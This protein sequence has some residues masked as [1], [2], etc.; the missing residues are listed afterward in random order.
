MFS[1][2]KLDYLLRILDDKEFNPVAYDNKVRTKIK[3]LYH[4]LDEIQSIGDDEYKVLYFCVEKGTIE[5]YISNEGFESDDEKILEYFHQ[6]NPEDLKWYKL[7]TV[8]YK[9][10]YSILLNSKKVIYADLDLEN[11]HYEIFQLQELLDFLI[12]NVHDCIQR[13]KS[14]TYN[15][16]IEK[17]LSYRN[18]FGV[19]KRS[20][21][22]N[23]YPDVKKSLLDEISQ[24]KIN[25]FLKY[26]GSI[27]LKP[28]KRMTSGK[29]F[30]CVKLAYES[31]GYDVGNMTGKEL[32][33]K[34][35]DGRDG[36]LCKLNQDSSKEFDDWFHSETYFGAHP[37]EIIRGHSFSRVNLYIS[38]D[39]GYYLCLDGTQMLSKIE[40]AK[41]YLSLIKNNIPVQI[42]Q[43]SYIREALLGNDYIGIVPDYQLPLQC[44][45]HFKE[46][47]PVEFIHMEDEKIL[48]Y[49]KWEKLEEVSLKKSSV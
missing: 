49:I 42:N 38:Y 44:Q 41:I 15:D 9:N 14:G 39:D 7:E 28:I 31:N 6:D 36:G 17:N 29:Y 26:T 3:E 25:L 43:N 13:L 19:I 8:R 1:A 27:K 46:Y 48:K 4:L 32:Y 24:E 30:E 20:D 16:F 5:E 33:L 18:R 34:Y 11:Q 12:L 45:G 22:W 23:L 37:W 2:L 47:K 21:Y 10:Y 40:I 35:A